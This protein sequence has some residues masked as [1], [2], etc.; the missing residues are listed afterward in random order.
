MYLYARSPPGLR[1]IPRGLRAVSARSRA[2]PRDPARIARLWILMIQYNI[3]KHKEY[4]NITQYSP[5]NCVR[6]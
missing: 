2:I 5:S 6:S 4:H 3:V 1:A